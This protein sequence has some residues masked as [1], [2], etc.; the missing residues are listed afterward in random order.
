MKKM[1]QPN[2]AFLIVV[3]LAFNKVLAIN[4]QKIKIYI[5]YQ[6]PTLAYP[7]I[8]KTDIKIKMVKII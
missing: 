3:I 1:R 5:L 8:I 6:V 4:K 7:L 2:Q